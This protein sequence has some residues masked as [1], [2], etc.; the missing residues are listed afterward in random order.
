MDTASCRSTHRGSVHLGEHRRG[1]RPQL[2]GRSPQLLRNRPRLRAGVRS[3]PRIGPTSR[4]AHFRGPRG[5]QGASRGDC[6]DALR[7]TQ[8]PRK[9]RG[10]KDARR[11][12]LATANLTE[13]ALSVTRR[14]TSRANREHDGDVR[15]R[16]YAAGVLDA[17]SDS[18]CSRTGRC[19][20]AFCPC[21]GIHLSGDK[22]EIL[23]SPRRAED[24]RA[25]LP[26]PARRVAGRPCLRIG[27]KVP[28]G[29]EGTTRPDAAGGLQARHGGVQ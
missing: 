17:G 2:Q 7:P 6:P 22:Q 18:L 11:E 1:R 21:T 28:E 13:S 14:V 12:S 23:T 10:L 25:S 19:D 29:R 5:T 8:G 15:R 3:A 16:W 9:P 4:P 24:E 20:R 27:E 26:G